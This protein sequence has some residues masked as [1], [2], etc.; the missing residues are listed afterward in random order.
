MEQVGQGMIRKLSPLL[1]EGG[2]GNGIFIVIG[3]ESGRT[4]WLLCQ[5]LGVTFEKIW[6]RPL[7]RI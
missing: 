4:F 5:P 1:K 2:T 7:L 6:V 3:S